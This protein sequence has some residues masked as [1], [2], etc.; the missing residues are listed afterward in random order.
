MGIDLLELNSKL[1]H[2][3]NNECQKCT[4]LIEETF[5]DWE[6]KDHQRDDHYDHLFQSFDSLYGA[7]RAIN[8]PQLE[9]YFLVTRRYMRFL[10][11]I[12]KFSEVTVRQ[13]AL[14]KKLTDIMHSLTQAFC[15]HRRTNSV[16]YLE[17]VLQELE[18]EIKNIT[19]ANTSDNYLILV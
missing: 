4:S 5:A 3:F 8:E 13:K 9:R 2:H 17:D 7:A 18:S 14:L 6:R 19:V 10:S 12:E 16:E 1:L 11:R 15:S